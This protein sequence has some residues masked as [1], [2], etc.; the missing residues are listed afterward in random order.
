MSDDEE[1]LRPLARFVD[2]HIEDYVRDHVVGL[3]RGIVTAVSANQNNLAATLD[4]AAVPTPGIVF[5]EGQSP[6]VGDD[7]YVKR[8]PGLLI[9]D[10]IL[11][12]S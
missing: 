5:Y 2:A 12:R 8:R 10:G 11:K 7:I 1:V 9:L 6:V 3:A 4:G